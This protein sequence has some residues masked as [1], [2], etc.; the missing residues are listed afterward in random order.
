VVGDIKTASARIH[1]SSS[2]MIVTIGARL[3]ELPQKDCRSVFY[4]SQCTNRNAGGIC[5]CRFQALTPRRGS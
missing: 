4:A 2:V 5:R 1:V 3:T